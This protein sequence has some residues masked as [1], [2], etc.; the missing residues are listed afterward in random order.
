MFERLKLLLGP[1]KSREVG[2]RVRKTMAG[3]ESKLISKNIKL[4]FA[5][6]F[7]IGL[8]R[9]GTTLLYQ[10]MTKCLK[11]CYFNNLTDHFP[12]SPVLVSL[13]TSPFNGNRPHGDFS[14]YYGET[15]GWNAPSQG[16]LIW[17][18]WFGEDPC[19]IAAG[20]L[21]AKAQHEIRNTLALMEM[22]FR[23]PFVNKWPVNSVR[24]LA[25]AEIFPEAVFIRTH[26]NRLMVA[27]SILYGRKEFW[28][29]SGAWLSAKPSNYE[30]IK[31]KSN[32]DQVCEQI[33]Y[34]EKDMDRDSKIVGLERFLSI[35]YEQLCSSPA[36]IINKIR[37]F[38]AATPHGCNLLSRSDVPKQFPFSTT[39]KINRKEYESLRVCMK[40]LYQHKHDKTL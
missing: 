32:I 10:V 30:N 6:I 4:P 28:G 25:F 39:I 19:Y 17:R 2:L 13:L 34:V 22:A 15:I 21:D 31:S 14:S 16:G 20:L 26:R 29:D 38:Y 1:T 27:Q 3:I 8:P 9:S 37:G 5:P 40:K 35:D 7:I 33:F 11:M 18:E 36:D 24:I 12:K 23:A